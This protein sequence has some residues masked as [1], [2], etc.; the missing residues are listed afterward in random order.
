[1]SI[2]LQFA[3]NALGNG[4]GHFRA[5]AAAILFG[6]SLQPFVMVRLHTNSDFLNSGLAWHSGFSKAPHE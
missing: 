6:F 2:G 5:N 1:M 4:A 3:L